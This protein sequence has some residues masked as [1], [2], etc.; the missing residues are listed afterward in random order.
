MA[1]A[2]EESFNS[3]SSKGLG[4]GFEIK[5]RLTNIADGCFRA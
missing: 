2:R 5:V 1:T 4:G 3:P